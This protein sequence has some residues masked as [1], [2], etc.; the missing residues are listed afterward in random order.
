MACDW[1][2]HPITQLQFYRLVRPLRGSVCVLACLSEKNEKQ[3]KSRNHQVIFL[4]SDKKKKKKYQNLAFGNL[5]SMAGEI[6]MVD[7]VLCPLIL[8]L[9][10]FFNFMNVSFKVCVDIRDFISEFSVALYFFSTLI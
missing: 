5:H 7:Q 6:K 8:L 10:Q 2:E 3:R 9:P 4:G 1:F